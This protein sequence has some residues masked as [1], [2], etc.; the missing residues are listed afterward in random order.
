MATE[1]QIAATA[2]SMGNQGIY[3]TLAVDHHGDSYGQDGL[4]Y[5]QW[6]IGQA[7]SAAVAAAPALPAVPGDS[8]T[9]RQARLACDLAEAVLVELATRQWDEI[10]HRN[11]KFR[12]QVERLAR[13]EAE[14]LARGDG[15][16][17]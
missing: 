5:R 3:A 7:L 1:E 11:R 8:W 13:E 2:L 12:E 14:A 4:S 6:L 10:E 15:C 16:P 9:V 17:I